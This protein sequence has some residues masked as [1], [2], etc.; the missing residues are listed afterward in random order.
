[1]AQISYETTQFPLW[2]HF[3]DYSKRH[4]FFDKSNDGP[5]LTNSI[6]RRCRQWRSHPYQVG[7]SEYMRFISEFGKRAPGIV[8]DI[9][10]GVLNL[11]PKTMLAPDFAGRVVYCEDYGGVFKGF[12]NSEDGWAV[13]EIQDRPDLFEIADQVIEAVKKQ[14]ENMLK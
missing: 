14:Y 11:G 13:V 1:M 4:C 2:S 10:D 8:T 12:L 7:Q 6:E 5:F 3:L 9:P